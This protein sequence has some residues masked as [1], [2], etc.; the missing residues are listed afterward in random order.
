MLPAELGLAALVLAAGL[1][2][3]PS[4]A[5]QAKDPAGDRAPI[6]LDALD[7]PTALE[8]R[9]RDALATPDGA[10]RLAIA[11]GS[12]RL[13]DATVAAG[14]AVE[15][16]LLVI[17]G[18]AEIAGRLRGDLVTLDGDAVVRPGAVISGDVLTLGGAVRDEGGEILGE[19]RTLLGPRPAAAA[20]DPEEGGALAATGRRV[21]GLVGVFLTLCALGFA[22]VLFGRPQLEVVSDAVSHAFGRAFL[23]GLVGQILVLPTFGV[24]VAGL[25]LSVVGI[26]LL[27]FVAIVFALLV[28]AATLIG[29]LGVAHA[30]GETYTRRRLAQGAPIGSANSYRYVLG[31]LAALG[32]LWAA[33]ALFGWVPLAGNLVWGVAAVVTWLLGTTGFGAALLTR[34]GLRGQLGGRL[35]PPESLT[36]EFLWATPQFGVTAGRRTGPPGAP[37]GGA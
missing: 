32:G 19:V 35:I 30:M 34:G 25:I 1:G 9:L 27:P 33:W 26:L 21:A 17:G 20:A 29:Y 2:L 14:E 37:A 10:R 16:D 36:D 31:G 24:L 5:A 13:G 8:A 12:V 23:A 3:P 18:A 15:G 6:T 7:D 22:L 11:G 28:L 4:P